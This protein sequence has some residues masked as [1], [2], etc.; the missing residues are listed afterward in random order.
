ME[1]LSNLYAFIELI[2]VLAGI[3]FVARGLDAWME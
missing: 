1:T 3:A 2:L